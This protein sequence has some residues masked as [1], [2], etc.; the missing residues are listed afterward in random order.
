MLTQSVLKPG[1]VETTRVAPDL[2]RTGSRASKPAHAP[3]GPRIAGQGLN[4]SPGKCP[5][6]H[7]QTLHHKEIEMI[8]PKD[9]AATLQQRLDQ[10]QAPTSMMVSQPNATTTDRIR[11]SDGDGARVPGVTHAGSHHSSKDDERRKDGG[12]AQPGFKD[13]QGEG[14]E[15]NGKERSG[16]VSPLSLFENK[17][18]NAYQG[19]AKLADLSEMEKKWS[20]TA[21]LRH[22][23]VQNAPCPSV[24]Q[25]QPNKEEEAE[26]HA[27][28]SPCLARQLPIFHSHITNNSNEDDRSRSAKRIAPS[29]SRPSSKPKSKGRKTILRREER[30]KLKT[31]KVSMMNNITKSRQPVYHEGL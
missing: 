21:V 13:H 20:T 30:K 7:H 6:S 31:Q 3:D 28:S 18:I 25:P 29:G 19:T 14:D 23:Q 15:T 27:R 24:E 17:F 12:S 11:K 1:S 9:R 16:R 5:A 26:Q 10:L 22:F 2:P 8:S 4:I